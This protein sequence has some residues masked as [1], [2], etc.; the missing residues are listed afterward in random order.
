LT[1]T[2]AEGDPTE[3]GCHLQHRS[4]VFAVYSLIDAGRS[5]FS[6]FNLF[7]SLHFRRGGPSAAHRFGCG[8]ADRQ[9]E[10]QFAE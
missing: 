5:S 1:K 10:W 4:F 8:F 7:A 9:I 3:G 6:G 2:I